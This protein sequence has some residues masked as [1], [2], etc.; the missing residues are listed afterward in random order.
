MEEGRDGERQ[1][2]KED[3]MGASLGQSQVASPARR[4]THALS[5]DM[6][7]TS[8]PIPAT[9]IVSGGGRTRGSKS[10]ADGPDEGPRAPGGDVGGGCE[11]RD[12]ARA[13]AGDGGGDGGGGAAAAAGAE[14]Q[15]GAAVHG[16]GLQQGGPQDLHRPQA[17]G[18]RRGGRP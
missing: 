17:L 4:A 8:C 3:R 11:D 2:E 13:G 18:P 9:D 16:G 12:Q 10:D 1:W 5:G 14:R 7:L 6:Q 15:G